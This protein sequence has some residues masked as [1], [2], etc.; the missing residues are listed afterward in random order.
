MGRVAHLFS[1]APTCSHTVRTSCSIALR[2]RFPARQP[3]EL[4]RQRDDGHAD[5]TGLGHLLRAAVC[6]KC[7]TD[8]KTMTCTRRR[9]GLVIRCG[10]M[11]QVSHRPAAIT[12]RHPPGRQ[13]VSLPH[14]DGGGHSANPNP[15][16]PLLL[17][18]Q[19]DYL[20]GRAPLLVDHIQPQRRSTS[21]VPFPGAT[22]PG[23][24]GHSVRF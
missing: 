8:T 15:L 22:C 4:R 23:A 11:P 16:A 1:P 13:V 5:K 9:Q 18:Y 12:E 14:P 7:R 3:G 10:G 21:R 2:G 17:D 6:H 20:I 19:R 24:G